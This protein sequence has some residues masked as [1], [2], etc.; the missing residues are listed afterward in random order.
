MLPEF[1][2]LAIPRRRQRIGQILLAPLIIGYKLGIVSGTVV[3]AAIVRLGLSGV[4]YDHY[5]RKGREFASLVLPKVIRPEALEW[6]KW[7]KGQGDV[8]VVVSGALDIYLTQ[9]CRS[10]GVECICSTLEHRNGVLTGRYLGAQCV[11][12]EKARQVGARFDIGSFA[13][14]F[15]YGDT[16]EDKELLA[17]AS[18][19]FYQGREVHRA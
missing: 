15:A 9:W 11:Q 5:E 16:A 12:S 17:L 7:H 3:R 19:K 18:Q 1:F 10:Q 14:V 13:E 8:V 2:R 4:P 6:I